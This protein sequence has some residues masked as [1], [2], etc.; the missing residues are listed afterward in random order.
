MKRILVLCGSNSCRSQMAEGYLSFYA[1]Q[2]AIIDS[3]GLRR[4]EVHPLTIQV[5][6][7]D[8]INVNH[9]ISKT[10]H[11]FNGIYFDYLITLC[12]EAKEKLPKD[13]QYGQH[14]HFDVPD[15]AEAT[16]STLEKLEV[17]RSVR[18]QVKKRMLRL[19]GSRLIEERLATTQ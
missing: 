3:A 4:A 16:G 9:H 18:E 14:L 19:I 13:I 5:M 11:Q 17:F 7:E 2:W 1:K 8:S 15:P 12:E 6:E 10:Y